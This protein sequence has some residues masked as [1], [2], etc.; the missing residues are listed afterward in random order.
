MYLALVIEGE[1]F[2]HGAIDL[3]LGKVRKEEAA[4]LRILFVKD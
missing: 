1:P 2:V 4:Y 3:H